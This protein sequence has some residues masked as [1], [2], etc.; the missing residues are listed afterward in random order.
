[1]NMEKGLLPPF[2]TRV[3]VSQRDAADHGG[4]FAPMRDGRTDI[5]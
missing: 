3:H 5:P 2:A 1:M 4:V